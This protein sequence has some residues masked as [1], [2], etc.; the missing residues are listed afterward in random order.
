MPIRRQLA[1]YGTTVAAAGMLVFIVLLSGLGANGVREDQ[2]RN[3]GAMA[4]TAAAALESGA[5]ATAIRPLVVTDLRV[6]TEPFLVVLAADG[7]VRYTSGLLD[8]SAPRIPAAAVVVLAQ[9]L[10][11]ARRLSVAL[12][13]QLPV[14]QSFFWMLL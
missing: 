11:S 7:K 10:V 2:D 1:L 3:L 12:Q 14:L 4:D 9:T 5:S 13:A 6:G 8:G